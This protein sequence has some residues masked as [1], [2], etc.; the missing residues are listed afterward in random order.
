MDLFNNPMIDSAKRA[1][2][3]E[4]MEE[5]KKIGEYMYSDDK[6]KQVEHA[7]KISSS[8]PDL[9]FYA[10][11]ALKSGLNPKELTQPEIQAL[12]EKYGEKWYEQF[13][14]CKDDILDTLVFDKKIS[15][16]QRRATERKNKKKNK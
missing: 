1:L 6:F 3:P 16:Q 8:Q 11:K 10:E 4:Q 5:Y 7:N 9:L 2:S 13:D 15:R 14:L 12:Y